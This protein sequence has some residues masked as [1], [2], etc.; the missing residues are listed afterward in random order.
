MSNIFTENAYDIPV[1]FDQ[2]QS[3][4]ANEGFSFGVFRD[5][6]GQEWNDFIHD[7]DEYVLVA[8]G[9]L[10]IRVGDQVKTVGSGALV[11][12]PRN[13]FHSLKTLSS[14]GSVWL[15]GYGMWEQAN[16]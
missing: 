9:E 14:A 10:E 4:W 6:Q 1:D 15:Y 7:T 5:P 2:V 11:R 3:D 8:S 16:E 13:T 12:I